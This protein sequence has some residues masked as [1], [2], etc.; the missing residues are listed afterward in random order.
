MTGPD[1]S[2]DTAG[3]GAR[4]PAMFLERRSYRR[5]RLMDAAKLLPIFG[6]VLFLIPLLWLISGSEA[7]P[8]PTSRAITYIFVVW[9]LLIA[10]NALFGMG[11]KRWAET[12]VKSDQ[13]GELSPDE[14]KSL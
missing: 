5:R 4:G 3:H 14:D 6:A 1:G 12:W 8:V 10:V 7:G 13:G 2:D 9:A 11:V